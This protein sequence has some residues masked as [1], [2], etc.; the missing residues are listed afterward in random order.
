MRLGTENGLANRA[1]ER[2]TMCG[3]YTLRTPA[4]RFAELFDL[5]DLPELKPRYNIAPTQT[6][7]VV[8]LDDHS[9]RWTSMRWGLVPSWAKDPSIGN[10]MLNARSETAAEKPAFRMAMRQRR[11]LVPTDGFYEWK[12]QGKQKVPY[13]ITLRDEQPFAF[14]GLWE[15]WK[16][17]TGP[18]ETCTILTTSANEL[19]A[20]LHDRMPVILDRHDFAEWLEPRNTPEQVKHL[21]EPYPASAMQLREVPPVVNSPRNEGPQC[22]DQIAE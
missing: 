18:L 15:C 21:F 17:P 20:P 16:S 7:P 13:L 6:V 12:K 5:L 9:R 4:R 2:I 3:R 8:R 10:R 11:C 22:V 14:A 1:P 19:L